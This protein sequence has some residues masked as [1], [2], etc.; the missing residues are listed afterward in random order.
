MPIILYP[1]IIIVY[2]KM[3]IS[4]FIVNNNNLFATDQV[5]SRN[6]SPFPPENPPDNF[7][8]ILPGFLNIL[9][10]RILSQPTHLP[11]GL[12]R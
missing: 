7:S 6:V 11:V 2:L 8:G 12:Q 4:S 9:L 3:K 5:A 1:A 10:V